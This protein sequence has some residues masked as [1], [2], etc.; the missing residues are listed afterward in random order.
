MTF[1]DHIHQAFDTL[2]DR[3]RDNIAR[4]LKETATDLT[5]HARAERDA[6]VDE[7]AKARAALAQQVEQRSKEMVEAAMAAAREQSRTD[8]LAA[9]QRLIDAIRALD[10]ARSLTEILDTLASSAG[11]EASRVGV[12]LARAGELRGWRFT[13]FGPAFDAGSTIDDSGVIAEAIRT[14]A[15]VSSDTSL[16]SGTLA[17]PAFAALPSGRECLAA[18][19]AMG[20]ETVAVLY[21]DQGTGDEAE[22]RPSTPR[23]PDTIELLARHAARCLEAR[24]ASKAMRVLSERPGREEDSSRRASLPGS[25]ARATESDEEEAGRRYARLLV[26]EIKMYHEAAVIA[27]RRERDLATRLGG[28]IARARVLYEQRVPAGL[29]EFDDELVRTLAN[30]DRSLLGDTVAKLKA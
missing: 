8:D 24:T 11:R 29:R 6:A 13:G 20:G 7:A 19:I 16:N 12:L 5:A 22:P 18:P 30:G 10:R 15:A 9:S 4:E 3:L 2:T 26:S 27:G 28:E 1:D 21:A 14:G 23:W 25:L 17:A